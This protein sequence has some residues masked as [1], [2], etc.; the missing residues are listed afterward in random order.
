M[1]QIHIEFNSHQLQNSPSTRTTLLKLP[2]SGKEYL[3]FQTGRRTAQT[4]QCA[5]SRV[6]TK[7]IETII[8]IE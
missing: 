2:P 6:L 7:F 5:K 4:Y 8:S 1:D 3:C